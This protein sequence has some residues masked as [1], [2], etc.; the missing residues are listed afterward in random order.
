[1]REYTLRYQPL[2]AAALSLLVAG[3]ASAET[4]RIEGRA[5]LS[6]DE[7][8][9]SHFLAVDLGSG[10][11]CVLAGSDLNSRHAP[12]ST[13]KIPN[14]LIALETGAASGPEHAIAWD[15][16]ARP[17]ATYWPDAWRQDQTLQSAFKRSA[18]WYFQDVA[19]AVGSERYR[20]F[21]QEWSYGNSA[22]PDGDDGFWLGGLLA[23]SIEEQVAFIGMLLE[24]R[25]NVSSSH[26]EALFTVSTDLQLENGTLYGKTGSGPTEAGNFN[27]DFEGWYVGWFQSANADPIALAHYVRAQRYAD[28]RDFRRGAIPV[29]L[30]ECGF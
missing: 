22:V 24:G 20:T 8:R 6:P 14:F 16:I 2:S 27:G 1:M 10:S 5:L 29:L 18:A 12:W 4:T 7:V 23:I 9:S 15:P 17:A 13:F 25:L 26:L 21:L 30:E 28:I 11:R 3:S 19:Q